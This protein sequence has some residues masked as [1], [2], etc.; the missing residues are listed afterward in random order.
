LVV[1][2]KCLELR[3]IDAGNRDRREEA[4]D[5]ERAEHEKNARASVFVFKDE[6]YFANECFPHSYAIVASLL[7]QARFADAGE[8]G[9]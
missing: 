3:G 7:F 5:D 4:E 8:I 6:L 1:V 2:K 9:T